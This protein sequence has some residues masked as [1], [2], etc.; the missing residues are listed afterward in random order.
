MK[1]YSHISGS[2]LQWVSSVVKILFEVVCRLAL[3]GSMDMTKAGKQYG[4]IIAQIRIYM[5]QTQYHNFM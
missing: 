1:E 3:H 4:Y 2:Q 5:C